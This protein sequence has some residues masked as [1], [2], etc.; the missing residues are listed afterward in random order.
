VSRNTILFDA[1]VKNQKNIKDESTTEI[2]ENTE[3]C[4]YI[5]D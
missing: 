2:T 1:I 4:F 3:D 5:P